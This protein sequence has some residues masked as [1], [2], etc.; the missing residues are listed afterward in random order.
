[1][2]FV[3][4]RLRRLE[5][6]PIVLIWF[7]IHYRPYFTQ[8]IRE[9][10]PG[11]HARPYKAGVAALPYW[12]LVLYIGMPLGIYFFETCFLKS[13]VHK[14]SRTEV[15]PVHKACSF[16]VLLFIS[17]NISYSPWASSNSSIFVSIFF[18]YSSKTLL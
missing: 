7:L 9:R 2:Y 15:I 12:I 17:Y 18:H 16:S 5:S 6:K 4:C 8:N 10:F 11:F 13:G 14:C 1:M 3:M